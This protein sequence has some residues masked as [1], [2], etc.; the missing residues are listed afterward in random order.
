MN[1]RKHHGVTLVELLIA[2]TVM[3][4]VAAAIGALAIAV[5][6]SNEHSQG[7]G[8]S[9]Q[10]ARIALQRIERTLLEAHASE[11]FP[12]FVAFAETVQ[13]WDFPDTLVVWH[14]N[15][16]PANP[17]GL[18]LVSELV[19]Y[20][21][22]PAEPN[23]LLEITVP[24]D[25]RTVP[26]LTNQQTWLQGLPTLKTSS[27]AIRVRLTDRLRVASVDGTALDGSSRRG[28]VRF[29]VLVRPTPG[30]WT[31]FRNGEINWEEID[32]V[33]DLFGSQTGLRQSWCRIELQLLPEVSTEPVSAD[34]A[35]PYFGSAALYHQL[36][37]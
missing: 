29:E 25:T 7:Q 22:D 4:M 14:P 18:P 21:P 36:T 12:G 1:R 24:G 33:Q 13:T 16:T 31:D 19:I 23:V 15:T 27:S 26:P 11:H 8:T 20:C 32:W 37:R 3:S 9:T 34:L 35:I 28:A 2:A 30:Q 10:H 5:Q 17:D 6:T